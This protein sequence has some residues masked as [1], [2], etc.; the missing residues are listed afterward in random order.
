MLI[1]FSNCAAIE[2]PEKHDN[3]S[4]SFMSVD[5]LVQPLEIIVLHIISVGNP[6]YTARA[7]G[8]YFRS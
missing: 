4:G 8:M 1:Y 2:F 3:F 6:I 7:N 5:Q